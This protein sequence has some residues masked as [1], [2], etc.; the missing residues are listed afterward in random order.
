[1]KNK[2]FIILTITILAGSFL[3]LYN[4]SNTARFNND[5]V[6]DAKIIDLMYEKNEFPIFG[7]KAGG[8]EFN[9]GPAFY[10]MEYF[11]GIIFRKNPSGIGLFIPILS[12]F[13]IILFYLFFRK[14]FYTE[15]AIFLTILYSFSFYVIK[16]SKFAWNPNVI[17]FFLLAFLNLAILIISKKRSAYFHILIAVVTGIAIQLHTIL[18]ILLPFA[19]I[20][21]YINI[22][23]KNKKIP[24]KKIFLVTATIIFLN[25]PYIIGNFSN[26]NIE[27][28][29]T[30]T[31]N[32]TTQDF[33][34][35]GN[36][37]ETLNFTTQSV[38]Y[39]LTGIEPQKN[40]LNPFKLVLSNN[41]TEIF[42]YFF[43]IIILFFGIL[44]FYKNI[45]RETGERKNILKFILFFLILSFLIFLSIGNELNIR[46][47]ITIIF[48]PFLL[49][50]FFILFIIDNIKIFKNNNFILV[51]F[52]II[53]IF[54][55]ISKYIKTYDLENYREKDSVY[56]GISLF[57][58]KKIANLIKEEQ[59]NNP[60]KDMLMLPWEFKKSIEYFTLKSEIKIN[61]FKKNN[62]SNEGL[63]FLIISD[64][65]NEE[66]I[67]E[68]TT[69]F[70][71]LKKEKVGRFYVIAMLPKNKPY[72]VGF[73]TDIHARTQKKYAYTLSTQLSNTLNYFVSK[74]NN[75]F[76][77]DFSVQ[78]GDLIDGTNRRGEKSIQDLNDTIEI[79]SKLNNP[80]LN[81]LGNHDLRG[82]A[83]K[84][85]LD[86]LKIDNAYYT[87][88]KEDL[89]IMVLNGND[90]ADI[91]D[92]SLYDISEKQFLWIEE[93]LSKN[94]SRKLVFV[95]YPIVTKHMEPGDKTLPLED[96]ERLKELFSKNNVLAVFSGHI[97]KLELNE[98]DG[99]KYFV[100]PGIERSE[101]KTI[102]WYDSFA[103]ITV[104]DNVS[105]NY[106]YKKNREEK[107]YKTLAIPSAEFDA[108]EK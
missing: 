30:G 101:N 32:K 88:E 61:K 75:D 83:Q 36:I 65:T 55:N 69:S 80:L 78:C 62:S 37:S 84:Q 68:K 53:F 41:F 79:L 34:L 47:F 38:T 35:I 14:I 16:Y 40:W 72:K 23:Q 2:I 73:I 5:Q 22:Y 24:L 77:P 87:I 21:I 54:L 51:F 104:K 105:I 93:N 66:K 63:V 70:S 43:S 10:Y 89:T 85:W 95:H 100:I 3:R 76:K 92:D 9:L 48:L 11:S 97:E 106:Y 27:N 67:K 29:I 44:F 4:F 15:I 45:K 28:F 25:I 86:L 19:L 98:E 42:L 31:K 60:Q 20:G 107:I 94:Y 74:M 50:G 33:S 90:T 18:L 71:V 56:G 39:T 103:E 7:P 108:I 1:M 102:Q 17:P 82:L 58:S 26:N 8:T 12:S 99:V 57:E 13:S 6:R 91:E 46:F 81:V 59:K 52:S 49:F 96:R 64:K